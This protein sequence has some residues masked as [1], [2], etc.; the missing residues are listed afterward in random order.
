VLTKI[1]RYEAIVYNY[2]PPLNDEKTKVTNQIVSTLFRGLMSKNLKE[3]DLKLPHVNFVYDRAF[4]YATCHSPS[5]TCYG[6]N[7]FTI[8][9]NLLH[10]TIEDRV[11]FEDQERVKEIKKLYEQIQAQKEKVNT[12]YN[13]AVNKH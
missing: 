4:T 10:L 9:I 13:T 1:I 8:L 3:W 7:P 2:F 6:I 11:S 12:S 5:Q